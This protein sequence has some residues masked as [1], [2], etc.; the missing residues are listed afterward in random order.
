MSDV[1]DGDVYDSIEYAQYRLIM[2]EYAAYHY[3]RLELEAERARELETYTLPPFDEWYREYLASPEWRTRAEEA[4]RRA[5]GRC[6]L[7]NSSGPLQAH[8]RTYDR[9]GNEAPDDLVALCDDCH[10]GYHR[11]RRGDPR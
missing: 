4:K 1:T 6:M 9:V 10:A 7:C 3:A 5:G 11:W 2:D 8:H